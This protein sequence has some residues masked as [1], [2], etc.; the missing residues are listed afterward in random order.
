MTDLVPAVAPPVRGEPVI[1]D[2]SHPQ[3]D[4]KRLFE[5]A[6]DKARETLGLEHPISG[7]LAWAAHDYDTDRW[8]S[9]RWPVAENVGRI[10][11]MLLAGELLK[12]PSL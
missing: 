3:W 4:G 11:E 12:E 8:Y 1:L 6:R 7:L 10:A 9:W 2:R 5:A